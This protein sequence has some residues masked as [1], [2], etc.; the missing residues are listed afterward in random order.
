M[1]SPIYCIISPQGI[2]TSEVEGLLPNRSPSI[3]E[4]AIDMLDVPAT[5]VDS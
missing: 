3:F 4:L 5:L 1:K 2:C